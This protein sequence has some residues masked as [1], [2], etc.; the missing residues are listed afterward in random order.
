MAKKS[1][2]LVPS[3]K[4]ATQK[5]AVI[6]AG[7]RSKRASARRRKRRHCSNSSANHLGCP[8]RRRLRAIKIIERAMHKQIVDFPGGRARRCGHDVELGM[9]TPRRSNEQ[10]QNPVVKVRRVV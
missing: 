8:T 4:D 6:E 1:D 9:S 5:I 2:S 3:A 10:E 7:A